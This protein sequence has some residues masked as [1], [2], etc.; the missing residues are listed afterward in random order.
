MRFKGL[1]KDLLIHLT[2]YEDYFLSDGEKAF[3][4]TSYQSIRSAL[5]IDPDNDL[6]SLLDLVEF[7][8]FYDGSAL[9][10]DRKIIQL[11]E[12]RRNSLKAYLSNI[13]YERIET[14]ASEAYTVNDRTVIG[15][16]LQEFLTA[17]NYHEIWNLVSEENNDFTKLNLVKLILESE[18]NS[19]YNGNIVF[20][21]LYSDYIQP[22]LFA[23]R[24]LKELDA[25][26]DKFLA[27]DRTT[28]NALLLELGRDSQFLLS[29]SQRI[30]NAQSSISEILESLSIIKTDLLDDG[31][32]SI[33]NK[34]ALKSI[35]N[36]F[37]YWL[38]Q[39]V[40]IY[41]ELHDFA[42]NEKNEATSYF[43]LRDNQ[44]ISWTDCQLDSKNSLSDNCW[45]EYLAYRASQQ[46]YKKLH[47]GKL[48]LK[49]RD[50]ADNSILTIQA[51]W[52][53]DPDQPPQLLPIA[54]FYL[55]RLGW[56]LIPSESALLVDRIN[57]DLVGSNPNISPSNFKP[58]AGASLLWTYS[59]GRLVKGK[60]EL[61]FLGSIEPSVGINVS[62]L[63]F[64]TSKDF[65]VGAGLMVGLFS[66]KLFFSYGYNF[67][68]EGI[69]PGYLGI[70]FSFLNVFSTINDAIEKRPNE[71]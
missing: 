54:T 4:R 45:A 71:L 37:P 55:R 23:Q 2:D 28:L 68:A 15:P 5:N 57:D 46:I 61:G 51:I 24:N 52:H 16:K 49:S 65:E 21:I 10:T 63:D 1:K 31:Q 41:S 70:G 13:L 6:L 32:I 64:S 67:S 20:N 38:D 34:L 27:S 11:N 58:A 59:K 66:N 69:A 48:Q 3:L 18:Q 62:Y 42:E 35:S 33:G 26:F 43:Q 14:K 44:N 29:I 12:N 25:Y 47:I 53:T 39:F 36:E 7:G 17:I 19:S 50:I 40:S 56:N 9:I 30:K 8:R 22:A 60:N